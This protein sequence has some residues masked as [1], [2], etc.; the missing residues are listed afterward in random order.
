MDMSNMDTGNMDMGNMDMGTTKM[1]NMNM[2]GKT[3]MMDMSGM[4]GMSGM[5][6]M[7]QYY[8]VGY[9]EYVLFYDLRTLSAGAMVGACFAIFA[10][11]IFYEAIKFFREYLLERFAHKQTSNVGI[12]NGSYDNPFATGSVDE[13]HETPKLQRIPVTA[14]R[15]ILDPG[16]FLQTAL[17]LL[18]VFISYCLMLVVMTF[19]VWLL[20]AVIVGAAV[21]YFFFGWMRRSVTD[22][23]EH[24]Q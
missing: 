11:S 22:S 24:C 2:D 10:L 21:G 13:K 14:R 18:Q 4:A 9:S 8:H 15:G 5:E 23:N 7:S 6:M 16:H 20:L 3:T 1:A 17:H 12:I 19:N